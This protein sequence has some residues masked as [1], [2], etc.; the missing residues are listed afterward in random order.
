MRRCERVSDV[1]RLR[2]DEQ[3][4]RGRRLSLHGN[5]F[6][7]STPDDQD[8]CTED[9]KDRD[10]GADH[11]PK[12][13][14]TFRPVLVYGRGRYRHAY[15]MRLKPGAGA[16]ET[17][18]AANSCPQVVSPGVSCRAPRLRPIRWQIWILRFR[19]F[20]RCW[21]IPRLGIT[22]CVPY[23]AWRGWPSRACRVSSYDLH[24]LCGALL[25]P[26]FDPVPV[27]EHSG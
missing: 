7:G 27:A 26:T 18:F 22:S 23:G 20:L 11:N 16:P 14:R 2:A 24:R 8:R 12:K 17:E 15:G 21:S 19:Y 5:H 3:G 1:E 10:G 25:R 6:L 9:Q 4:L 13:V